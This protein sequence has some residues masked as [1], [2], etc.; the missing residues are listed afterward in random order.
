M[1]VESPRRIGFLGQGWCPDPG[2]VETHTRALAHGWL[3]HGVEVSALAFGEPGTGV[4]GVLSGGVRLRRVPRP[5]VQDFAGVDDHPQTAAHLQEWLREE[6]PDFVHVHHLAGWG[7]GALDLL[8]RLGIPFAV[9]LHD[10]WLLCLRGQRWHVEHHACSTPEPAECAR[11]LRVSHPQLGA[12]PAALGARLERT[13]R[14]LAYAEEVLV[15]SSAVAEAH[16][17]AGL[18]V[19]MVVVELGVRTTALNKAVNSLRLPASEGQ[20]LHLGYLGSVQPAKGVVELAEAVVEA[21]R[22]DLILDVHGPRRA[23]HGDSSAVDRLEQLAAEHPCLRL[24]PAYHPDHLPPILAA[25][26]AVAMPSLWDEGFGLVAREARAVGLPV[27]VS[28]HAGLASLAR[29]PGATLL[30]AGDRAAWVSALGTLQRGLI[31]PPASLRHETQMVE[32]T[33]EILGRHLWPTAT[34]F[35]GAA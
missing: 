31:P 20:P 29:D 14:L 19:P 6:R 23:T 17:R 11:C 8:H 2:G 26:D 27:L 32:E 25:L 22:S 18:D 10:D 4:H 35:D 28:S 33:L 9:T 16:R 21:G 15:P 1:G 24:H 30:P 12:S 34:R 3:E 13:A 7:L 5:R